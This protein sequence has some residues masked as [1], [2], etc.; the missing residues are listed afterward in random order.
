MRRVHVMLITKKQNGNNYYYLINSL[1]RLLSCNYK[2]RQRTHFCERS[3]QGFNIERALNQRTENCKRIEGQAVR[4]EMPEKG[5]HILR[6]EN[7]KKELKVPYVISAD[8]ESFVL[9]IDT[10]LPNPSESST[11]KTSDH[12]TCGFAYTTCRG[13]TGRHT[14]RRGTVTF[15]KSRL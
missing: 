3:L 5:V 9:E 6:F 14:T 4:I 2:T 10:C 1:S 15:T 12:V 8:C 7:Y 11:K 13:R